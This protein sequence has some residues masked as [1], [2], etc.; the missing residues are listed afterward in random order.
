MTSLEEEIVFL[1]STSDHLLDLLGF[2]V[3]LY[4]QTLQY[5]RL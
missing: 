5:S 3:Y 4:P 1:Q 2:I